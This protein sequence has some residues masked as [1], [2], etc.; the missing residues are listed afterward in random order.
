MFICNMLIYMLNKIAPSTWPALCS[1]KHPGKSSLWRAYNLKIQHGEKCNFLFKT[2]LEIVQAV[3]EETDMR[4]AD[5]KKATMEFEKD[6]VK[7][8]TMKK[9]SVIASEKVLQYMEDRIH[10][11]VS[12]GLPQSSIPSHK[13]CHWH[14]RGKGRAWGRSSPGATF[15]FTQLSPS[16]VTHW[17]GPALYLLCHIFQYLCLWLRAPI[18]DCNSPWVLQQ[19][20]G[21]KMQSNKRK[22][23]WDALTPRHPALLIYSLLSQ[24]ELYKSNGILTYICSSS[25]RLI[26]SLP[27][28]S[29]AAAFLAGD[30]GI[31]SII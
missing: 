26:H 19:R 28:R 13:R 12:G 9:G 10:A 3:L 6:I 30:T 31:R 18:L 20:G 4:M 23:A 14:Q 27:V 8:L 1:V 5:I 15:G 24:P 21:M 16:W 17:G 29:W 7:T 25:S 22:T 11:R 2:L